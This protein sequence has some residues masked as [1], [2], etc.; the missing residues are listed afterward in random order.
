MKRDIGR[1]LPLMMVAMML[2]VPL[3]SVVSGCLE[4]AG[5]QGSIGAPIDFAAEGYIPVTSAADLA[6][7]GSNQAY[8]DGRAWSLGERYYLTQDI[9]FG[10]TDDLNGGMDITFKVSVSG[11]SSGAEVTVTV[12]NPSQSGYSVYSLEA[13]IGAASEDAYGNT[14][15][16]TGVQRGDAILTVCGRIYTGS[17]YI[18]YSCTAPLDT[19]VNTDVAISRTFNSNG[20]FTPIG[21]DPSVSNLLDRYRSFY[22]TFNGNGHTIEGLDISVFNTSNSNQSYAGL[23]CSVSGG[24]QISDLGIVNSSIAAVG[25]G[26]EALSA[27]AGGIAGVI[28]SSTVI[29]CYN[30]GTITAA[31]GGGTQVAYAGGI[32]GQ[33]ESATMIGCYN[34][35]SITAT[36]QARLANAGGIA[37]NATSESLGPPSTVIGCYNEGAISSVRYAGGLFGSGDD[38]II[39]DCHNTGDVYAA[40][41]PSSPDDNSA[42]GGVIGNVRSGKISSSYNEGNVS[43]STIRWNTS[44]AYA[45]GIAG[46]VRTFTSDVVLI[47]DCHNTG[48]IS[49]SVAENT[50]TAGIVA[51]ISPY[52]NSS[53]GTVTVIGCYNE[54][55]IEGIGGSYS[56]YAYASG[57]VAH[58]YSLHMPVTVSECFNTGDVSATA[59]TRAIAGGITGDARISNSQ[60]QGS[61]PVKTYKGQVTIINCYNTGGVTTGSSGSPSY[62][63]G[64]LGQAHSEA[65]S[66]TVLGDLTVANCYNIGKV[67]TNTSYPD[68]VGGI[69]GT[70]RTWNEQITG[71]DSGM[72]TI[73]NCY[74]LEGQLWSGASGDSQKPDAACPQDC[75]PEIYDIG[76]LTG[77]GW[78]GACTVS[79]MQPS[80]SDAQGGSSVYYTGTTDINGKNVEGWDFDD[81]WMI[82]VGV[83][84]GYPTLRAKHYITS[85]AGHNGSVTPSGAAS[86]GEGSDKEFI[87]TANTGYM[88]GDVII[89]GVSAGPMTS[90]TFTGISEGHTIEVTFTQAVYTITSSSGPN[91]SVT[92]SGTVPVAYGSSQSYT[93]TPDQGYAISEVKVDGTAVYPV[94][95]SYTFYYVT[96]D[97]TIEVT[98]AKTYTI[99]ASAGPNGSVTPSGALPVAQGSSQSY[100]FT[101]DQGYAISEVKVDG[102]AVTPVKSSYTFT[103][104]SGDHTIEATFA[105]AEG[106]AADDTEDDLDMTLIIAALAVAAAVIAA[107]AYFFLIR[108]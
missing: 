91:G 12:D 17:Q 10:A 99:T 41:S 22:G 62:S 64:I 70:E 83:N 88:V 54:G 27:Y 96:S 52:G 82:D 39:T 33:I 40:V 7:I 104:V 38:M 3:A 89:D 59:G 20:N 72:W 66:R 1:H 32:A 69:A 21:Y 87:F 79:V 2:A 31:A 48:Q 49:A 74:Y 24:A 14:V 26:S 105:P 107:G 61:G 97:H 106:R 29:D 98:F 101:P 73:V 76:S 102:T 9:V 86:A 67:T 65:W 93:F 46:T 11:Y 23:F 56:M 84:N 71:P 13:Y 47:I 28:S 34:D 16:L 53:G 90:Y 57:I 37:G 36:S 58:M 19:S 95:S 15:K 30:K 6:L 50:Y 77:A 45:G 68:T 92:P 8:T 85:S 44:A 60:S 75:A 80:L 25:G 55:T 81:T 43:A 63:G 35:G 94:P 18:L 51:E 100:T 4:D 108:K 42:A 78:T 5:G 103:N